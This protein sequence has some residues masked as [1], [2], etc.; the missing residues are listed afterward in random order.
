[1]QDF[2]DKEYKGFVISKFPHPQLYGNYEIHHKK[3]GDFIDRTV[4]IKE[5][6]EL[7]NDYIIK[8]KH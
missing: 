3:S 5:A 6:K 1:M 8:P 7:I 4:T 2:D